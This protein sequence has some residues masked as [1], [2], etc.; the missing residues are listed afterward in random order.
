MEKFKADEAQEHPRWVWAEA[1]FP[2]VIH[3]SDIE[4]LHLSHYFLGTPIMRIAAWIIA[5]GCPVIGHYFQ[6]DAIEA[7]RAILST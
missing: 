5:A 1:A 4:S 2:A 7:R 6:H 3:F